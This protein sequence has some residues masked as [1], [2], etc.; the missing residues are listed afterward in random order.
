MRKRLRST[1]KWG[2]AVLTVLLLVVWVWSGQMW[3]G[4]D[5]LP[6]IT[7]IL[8]EGRLSVV[9][10]EPWSLPPEYG[11]GFWTWG[12]QYPEGRLKWW[13]DTHMIA[14]GT[15]RQLTG[16]EI[17]IWFFSLMTGLASTWLFWRDRRKQP[18]LCINCGYDLRGADHAV[19]P[20]C[21][22]AA[23]RALKAES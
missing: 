6:H 17:P 18:G 19:C 5:L 20:E 9:W 7:L 11:T 13:V 23:P 4:G 12:D 16:A 2:G 3:I 1:I 15:G 14:D 21:G 22:A 10:E 8:T